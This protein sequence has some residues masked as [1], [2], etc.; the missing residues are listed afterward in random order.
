[1]QGEQQRQRVGVGSAEER[2]EFKFGAAGDTH[3]PAEEGLV[4]F[5]AVVAEEGLAYFIAVVA[6]KAALPGREL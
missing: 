5:I 4:Y 3:R 1:M 6:G 2:E